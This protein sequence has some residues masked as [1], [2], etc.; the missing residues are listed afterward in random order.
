VTIRLPRVIGTPVDGT[1]TL[2]GTAA[3]HDL[4]VLAA[5]IRG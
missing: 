3:D 5:L 4:G 1:A 2:T